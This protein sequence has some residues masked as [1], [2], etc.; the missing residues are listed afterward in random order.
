MGLLNSLMA[1][2]AFFRA[3]LGQAHAATVLIT[4]ANQGIG[5]AQLAKTYIEHWKPKSAVDTRLGPHPMPFIEHLLT[6]GELHL[7]LLPDQSVIH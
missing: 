6:A 7:G 5:D 2:V 1:R 4:G 3:M